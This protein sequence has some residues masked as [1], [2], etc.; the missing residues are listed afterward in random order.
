MSTEYRIE[1]EGAQFTVIDPWGEKVDT[2][3]TIEA[4]K[5]KPT[6]EVLG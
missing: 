6:R 5:R 3:P 1:P 4:P 2:Y